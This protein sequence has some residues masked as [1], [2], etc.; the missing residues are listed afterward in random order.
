MRILLLWS[1]SVVLTALCT[2]DFLNITLWIEVI[3]T[4]ARS[5]DKMFVEI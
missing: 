3:V 4:I 5:P 1:Y 2:V